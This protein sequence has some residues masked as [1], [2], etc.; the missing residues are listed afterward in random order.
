MNKNPEKFIEIERVAYRLP[1]GIRSKFN[2]SANIMTLICDE[3]YF[4]H[5]VWCASIRT[6]P[7]IHIH[8]T[9]G[10]FAPHPT[11]N[12]LKHWCE[13]NGLEFRQ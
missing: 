10:Y 13:K 9:H 3:P 4:G 2:E 7:N 5:Y 1:N 12:K 11:G 8:P 6:S